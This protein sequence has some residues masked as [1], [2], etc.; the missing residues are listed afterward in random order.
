M[1][2]EGIV[3]DESRLPTGSRF[4]RKNED[5]SEVYNVPVETGG[6]LVFGE[7]TFPPEPE[8]DQN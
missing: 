2:K 6:G 3:V 4:V 8:P 7:E 1:R 5:G